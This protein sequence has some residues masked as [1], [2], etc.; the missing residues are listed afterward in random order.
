[1]P[2]SLFLAKIIG[3][4]TLVIGIGLL[5]NLRTYQVLME[6][7]AKSPALIYLGGVAALFLGAWILSRH[8]IWVANWSIVIT[9]I[10]WLSLIKGALLLIFP[11]ALGKFL[12]VYQKN[13]GLLALHSV[14]VI[15]I[16]MILT[17]FGYFAL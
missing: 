8:N 6:D 12:G 13:K 1:M 14:V 9:I 10:G 11:R 15:F 7:F 4:V 17:F 16:G 5:F 3:P 2:L